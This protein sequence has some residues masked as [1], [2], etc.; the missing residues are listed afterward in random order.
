MWL[1]ISKHVVSPGAHPLFGD[2]LVFFLYSHQSQDEH[3]ELHV[4]YEGPGEGAG[5]HPDRGHPGRVHAEVWQGARRGIP[6]WWAADKEEAKKTKK[7]SVLYTLHE[8][9]VA[10]FYSLKMHEPVLHTRCPK[11]ALYSAQLKTR[12]R[13]AS[14]RR[15]A[16]CLSV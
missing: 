14:D 7:H 16:V 6:L 4:P 12:Y 2:S 10:P 15:L 11:F 1:Y 13:K 9:K 5:L 8:N 3:D